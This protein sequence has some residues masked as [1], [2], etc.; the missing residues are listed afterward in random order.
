MRKA[1]IEEGQILPRWGIALMLILFPSRIKL[2]IGA[3]VYDVASDTI[4]VGRV[5]LPLYALERTFGKASPPGHWFRVIGTTES[6]F[7]IIECR[8]DG[9]EIPSNATDQRRPPFSGASAESAL[10]GGAAPHGE[11]DGI[12]RTE[13]APR[14]LSIALSGANGGSAE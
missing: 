10:L 13:R 8:T 14:P 3:S 7:P 1:G 12:R 4:R 6:G 9:Y 11:A 2:W 5:R